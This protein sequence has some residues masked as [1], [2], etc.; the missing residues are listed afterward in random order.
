[1]SSYGPP[2]PP[3]HPQTFPISTWIVKKKNRE[4]LDFSV[5][6]C[7]VVF[8]W[9]QAP[10]ALHTSFPNTE[11]GIAFGKKGTSAT[12]RKRRQDTLAPQPT[13]PKNDLRVLKG[14]YREKTWYPAKNKIAPSSDSGGLDTTE[15]SGNIFC[16]EIDPASPNFCLSE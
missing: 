7:F 5:F 2:H 14:T 15:M 8:V 16:V 12:T 11:I 6:R 10:P 1:M 9:P 4:R 13:P 3:G